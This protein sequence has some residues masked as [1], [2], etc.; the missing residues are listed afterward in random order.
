MNLL[1]GIGECKS[2]DVVRSKPITIYLNRKW[3][4]LAFNFYLFTM[5]VFLILILSTSFI[6]T[7]SPNLVTTDIATDS[8]DETTDEAETD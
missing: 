2:D 8:S 1:K 7:Y 4:A 3:N 5:V 6:T